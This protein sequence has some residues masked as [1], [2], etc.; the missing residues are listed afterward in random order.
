[1]KR[2]FLAAALITA[3]GL[4]AAQA[5]PAASY[6]N[7]GVV[8]VSPSYPPYT[9]QVRVAGAYSCRDARLLIGASV[10]PGPLPLRCSNA[11]G[12]RASR[13]VCA[14]KSSRTGKWSRIIAQ[15]K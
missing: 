14:G 10:K 15:R 5:A 11:P 9:M 7:C 12:E 8:D 13:I 1:M 3:G 2:I 6:R 4:S